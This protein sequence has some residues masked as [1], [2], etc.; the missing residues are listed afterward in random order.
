M[1]VR[2]WPL[3]LLAAL[4]VSSPAPGQ[5]RTVPDSGTNALRQQIE[6]LEA[7]LD[8]AVA[9]VSV[10][11]A[12][13]LMGRVDATRG[14]RLPG[15]GVLFVLA[16]R[17]L[18][19]DSTLFVFKGRGAPPH[20][21]PGPAAGPGPQGWEVGEG[22]PTWEPERV[23]EIERQV[24]VLQHVAEAERRAA[25]EDMERIVHQVRIRLAT[26]PPPEHPA[27]PAP[28]PSGGEDVTAPVPPGSTSPEEL[29]LPETPPWRFWFE[30]EDSGE[31]RSPDKVVEEV[32]GAVIGTLEAQAGRVAGLG[33]EEWV[34]VAVD[35][36]PGALFASHPRPERTLVVRARQRDLE[37]LA[38]GA[39][40]PAE[41]EKRVEVFEY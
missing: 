2:A 19:G 1:S 4:L 5:D 20:A 29:E 24:L 38:K 7:H 18:P 33:A 27:S 8:R 37:R 30:T 15:Y 21:L 11:H 23:E 41:L 26:P 17:A 3:A 14:Y 40:A 10:P 31:P 34:T 6:S 35:F 12:G 28:A 13:I 39:L 32:K 25:E 16:P 36:V 9:R 22:D